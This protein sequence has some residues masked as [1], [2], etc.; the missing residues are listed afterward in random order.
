MENLAAFEFDKL[1]RVWHSV[2]STYITY[3]TVWC[4]FNLAIGNKT[5]LIPLPMFPIIWYCKGKELTFGHH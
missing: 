1:E 4:K 2:Q 5:K 3:V